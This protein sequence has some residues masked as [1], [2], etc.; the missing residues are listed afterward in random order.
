MKAKIIILCLS[1]MTIS[2][3]V[4]AQKQWTLKDCIDFAIENNIQIQQNKLSIEEGDLRLNTSKNSRLPY[5]GADLG[6]STYFG[7]SLSRDGVY[8]DQNQVSTNFGVSMQLPVY[9]G[10]RIKNEILSRELDLKSII[11]SYNNAKE[12]LSLNITSMYVS[13]LYNK[14][15]LVVAKNQAAQSI[16]MSDKSKI[17]FDSGRISESEYYESLSVLANDKLLVVE[18]SNRLTLSL[19]DL[20][21][22]LNLENHVNFDIAIPSIDG[23]AA[24]TFAKLIPADEIFRYAVDLRPNILSH[25]Y[26][27]QS[28]EK[29][30]KVAKSAYMPRISFN[31]GYNTGYYYS[32][33]DGAV[34]QPF[35]NQL[36]INGRES[37]G[38]NV[39]IPIFNRLQTRNNVRMTEVGIKNQNLVLKDTKQKLQK[40]IE[41][42]YQNATSSKEN[43]FASFEALRAAKIAFDFE[44]NKADA[45]R[46]TIFDF[47]DSKNR[48]TRAESELARAKY[49]FLFNKKILDY[50]YGIPLTK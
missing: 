39:S 21:H 25:E 47:N 5:I 33:S 6:G 37:V 1:M 4:F 12:D 10:S 3:S 23:V 20:A 34:N 45:G 13:I 50:Y 48:L 40:E 49:Q 46:S 32:F 8:V 16:E 19:L 7:R 26:K 24:E 30:L 31:A 28:M 36:D 2:L 15:L 11:A 35:G 9:E 27:L 22:V 43:Y 14:E 29:D 42:A 18:S 17:L 41:L 44:K 38:V